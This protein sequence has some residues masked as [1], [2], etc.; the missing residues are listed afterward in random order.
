MKTI[1]VV[2]DELGITNVVV[3]ALE[4]DGYRV[5]SASNGVEALQQVREANPDLV[6]CDF[7]M[8]LLD[9]AGLVQEM[10]S[11]QMHQSIPII[12]MSAM[13]ETVIRRRFDGYDAFLR[14][15]FRVA[16]LLESIRALVTEPRHDQD[17]ASSP[18]V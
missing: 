9:G 4:D 10:R 2:D 7:M 16:A 12:L 18:I 11:S 13:P 14:K 6:I 1:L 3:A 15:P 5:L 17:A 8:P